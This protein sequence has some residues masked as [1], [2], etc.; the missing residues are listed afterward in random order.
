MYLG[1]LVGMAARPLSILQ[2]HTGCGSATAEEARV[3]T[4]RPGA[5]QTQH[6][7]LTTADATGLTACLSPGPAC[8]H[9]HLCFHRHFLGRGGGK[10]ESE[11]AAEESTILTLEMKG[12]QVRE[13]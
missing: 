11:K 13:L 12:L 1:P 5:A 10:A 4:A 6:T 9:S 2:E 3:S 7:G 8:P